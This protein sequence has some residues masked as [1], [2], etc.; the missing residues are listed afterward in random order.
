MSSIEITR[1]GKQNVALGHGI[2]VDFPE[3]LFDEEKITFRYAVTAGVNFG[4]FKLPND[5]RL[6]S[7]ILSLHP[8][9]DVTFKKPIS[10][11]M[12][13]NLYSETDLIKG[14]KFC[15]AKVNNFRTVNGQKALVFSEVS[16]EAVSQ[17]SRPTQIE[18]YNEVKEFCATFNTLHTCHYCLASDHFY[19]QNISDDSQLYIVEIKPL[20]LGKSSDFYI[21]YAVFEFRALC[22]KV[23]TLLILLPVASFS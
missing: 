18:D 22:Y 2:S 6:I 15:K 3:G 21:T 20:N 14:I 1:S 17:F 16:A 4:L 10:I 13:H 23:S 5:G 7:A 12:P 19:K 11:T 9:K 8:E